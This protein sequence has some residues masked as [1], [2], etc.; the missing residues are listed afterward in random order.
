MVY[1]TNFE[2]FQ[3]ACEKLYLQNPKKVRY[4]VK[5]RNKDSKIVLKVTNDQVCI[6]YKTDQSGD[7]KKV[8]KF[9]NLLFRLMTG[10]N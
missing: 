8:E 9:N 7:I 1:I 10:K 6:K 3:E 2:E 4:V 5:Y